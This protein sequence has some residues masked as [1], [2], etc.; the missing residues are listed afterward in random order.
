MEVEE[1]RQ[2]PVALTHRWV[3]LVDSTRQIMS[4]QNA[5]EEAP[6]YTFRQAARDK[7]SSVSLSHG[8][9]RTGGRCS[10]PGKVGTLG[11][12]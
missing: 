9:V 2:A 5:S 4:Y 6:S 7:R 10:V 12:W 3:E 8:V 11:V 1:V